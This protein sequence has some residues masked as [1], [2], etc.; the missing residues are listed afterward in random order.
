MIWKI[1]IGLGVTLGV[2]WLALIVLV[3]LARPAGRSLREDMRIFPDTLGLLRQIA[4]DRGTPR[5]IRVR[6]ALLLAYLALPIDLIPDFIPGIG[7]ADDVI[8]V[9]FTLRSVVRRAGPAAVRAHWPG[10]PDGLAVLWRLA[11]LENLPAD[12][13]HQPVGDSEGKDP[14]MSLPVPEAGPTFD[15]DGRLIAGSSLDTH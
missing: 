11:R 12:P 10:T 3:V 13:P 15:A 2:L 4:V 9:A 1:L 5:G 8:I 7:Y 14:Q 6:L